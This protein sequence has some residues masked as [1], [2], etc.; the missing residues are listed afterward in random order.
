MHRRLFHKSLEVFIVPI[1]LQCALFPFI[2]ALSNAEN[3]KDGFC[4]SRLD[5][6]Y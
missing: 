4:N 2:P 6:F 5:H 3:L 1:S